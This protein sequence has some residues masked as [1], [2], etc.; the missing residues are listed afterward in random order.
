[1]GRGREGRESLME[2]EREE[3]K[4]GR[5]EREDTFRV[6][7]GEERREFRDEVLTHRRGPRGCRDVERR[8]SPEWA[9]ETKRN[10]CVRRHMYEGE[11]YV[12]LRENEPIID[13]MWVVFV[14]NTPRDGLE[15]VA[16]CPE[17]LR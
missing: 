16:R 9:S 10:A 4:E 3:R 2:G 6:G 13:G 11:S 8:P 1:M 17:V 5:R 15:T 14:V 7:Q 12:N